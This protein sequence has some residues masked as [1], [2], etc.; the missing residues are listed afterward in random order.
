MPQA[1]ALQPPARIGRDARP[2]PQQKPSG[3]VHPGPGTAPQGVPD[4]QLERLARL[5]PQVPA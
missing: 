1:V 4:T 2:L 5:A 3:G